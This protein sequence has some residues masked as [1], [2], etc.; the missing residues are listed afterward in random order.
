MYKNYEQQYLEM[1]KNILENGYYDT[2]RTGVSTYKL[3]H[4]IIRVDLQKEFPIL[5][6]KFVAFKT[7]VKELLWIYQKQSNDVGELQKQNVHIW[8][9]WVDEDNTIGKAYGYQISPTNRIMEIVPIKRRI[10]KREEKLTIQFFDL[11]EPEYTDDDK[12]GKFLKNIS[13]E[14]FRII[15]YV[16]TNKHYTKYYD[17]QFVK[18]GYIAKNRSW[19]NIIRGQIKDVY[20]RNNVGV[21]YI[22]E[23]DYKN[24]SKEI[25][26]KLLGVWEAML[27]RC[28]NSS[29]SNYMNYGAK[30][31]FVDERWHSF[32]NFVKDI[33]TLPNWSAKIKDW[34]N[35][36][37]DKDYYGANCYSKETCVWLHNSDNALY[38][39]NKGKLFKAEKDNFSKMYISKKQC[40]S[41][42]DLDSSA[43]QK[44]L[45]GKYKQH[46]G[47]T[48]EYI[49]EEDDIV[50]RYKLPTNQINKLIETIKS[51]P[52]DRRMVMSLWN[53]N[54]LTEM[55][56][57]PCCFMTIFDVTDGEL[58][59][60]LIQRLK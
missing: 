56:L 19:D 45:N 8:D 27:Q 12:I 28:Y 50:Y 5:K 39:G 40:A 10:K 26:Q 44:V 6:T 7:A 51:N 43:I 18:T 47:Y 37:L 25:E 46:K 23:K 35:Y 24:I 57:Q 30:G 41:E 11:V 60:S 2:N 1:C 48:F 16:G 22:G 15:K 17:V 34:S 13:G 3:P 38:S 55:M 52:Q 49:P 4:Q 36:Q 20:A 33:R 58:N 29:K 59:C 53:V 31:V 9:N 32:T 42:L 21:G 54:D 14:E